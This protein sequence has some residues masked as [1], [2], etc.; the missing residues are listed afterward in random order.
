MGIVSPELNSVDGLD[1]V[2]N[3]FSKMERLNVLYCHWKSNEHLREGLLG[4]T[5]LDV[6]VEKGN[7]RNLHRAL[8]DSGFKLFNAMATHGYPAVED[9]L[10]VDASTGRMVHLHLHYQLICGEPH[11]KGYRLPWEHQ[12][13]LGRHYDEEEKVYVVE[14]H[15]EMLL[16]IVRSI[17]KLRTRDRMLDKFGK[18]YFRGERLKEFIWLKER[19]SSSGM[20]ELTGPLLGKE[21][22]TQ[23]E[24]II[25]SD[26]PSLNQILR[27]R[28]STTQTI[29]LFRTYYPLHARWRRTVRELYWVCGGI[30][31]RYI[32]APIPL[33]R[34]SASGGLLIAIMGCDGSGKS[35]HVK[36]VQ[37]W[38]SWKMDVIS[39]Y[40]GSG[41]GP[42]SLIRWP[43]KLIAKLLPKSSKKSSNLNHSDVGTEGEKSNPSN[44]SLFKQWTKAIWATT[45]CIEK[46]RKLRRAT[47]ARNRGMVVLCDRYPQNQIMGFNDGPLLSS[48]LNHPW[49]ILRALAEWEGKPYR[50]ADTYLP[51]VVIRLNVSPDVAVQ[52]KSDISY[53]QC[54]K[55]INAINSLQYP[56][57]TRV[58]DIDANQPIEHVLLEVKHAIWREF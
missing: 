43:L 58:V 24:S 54:N 51:D 16:L 50:E 1:V 10:A 37:Q 56:A 5:D 41:D 7:T 12:I 46:H 53:E 35:T 4:I 52:R 29:Q 11:L 3:F 57:A 23:I 2:A 40:F 42:S 32:H 36:A 49:K 17:L 8:F 33:R 47:L 45:L 27:F 21:A 39:L 34:I 44:P 22:A 48:W 14:P 6:L 19:I 28:K 25:S 13:L 18:P 55:R 15:M 9:Y 26:A 31:K 30:N 20:Y 38:L